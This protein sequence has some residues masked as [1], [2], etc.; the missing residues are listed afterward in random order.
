MFLI[1]RSLRNYFSKKLTDLY[2]LT[3]NFPNIAE[4]T[5][6]TYK[7][8]EKSIIY[9]S[10]CCCFFSILQKRQNL[11]LYNYFSIYL[12]WWIYNYIWY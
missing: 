11:Y 10:S 7:K 4:Q 2:G 9:R 12:F 1:I 3:I 6:K 8:N 5:N